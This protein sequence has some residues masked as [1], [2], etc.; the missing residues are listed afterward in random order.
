MFYPGIDHLAVAASDSDVEHATAPFR[1]LGIG[2]AAPTVRAGQG[3]TSMGTYIGTGAEAVALEFHALTNREEALHAG[4]TEVALV[5]A[6]DRGRRLFTVYLGVE[7]ADVEAVVR[8]W[9]SHGLAATVSQSRNRFGQA[10]PTVHPSLP[11]VAAVDLALLGGLQLRYAARS[12][13]QVAPS[14]FPLKRLDHLAA[15]APD[16]DASTRF[17]SDVLEIPLFGEVRSA[18]SII[19][20]FKIGD[21]IIELLGP[22]TPDSPLAQRPPGLVSMAAFEVSDMAAAL[23]Q[24]RAAGFTV[25]DPAPGSLPGTRVTTIPGSELSGL[26]LQLLEYV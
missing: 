12:R 1:R 17:W 26:A 3:R 4:P 25:A 23:A 20:Q 16:L 13:M 19:R 8:S 10:M 7:D 2:F 11:A 22:A 15:V 21:A 9:R 5:E 14:T 24:A 6:V 18:T